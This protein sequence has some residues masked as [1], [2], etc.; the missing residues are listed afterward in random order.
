MTTGDGSAGLQ[1]GPA[2]ANRG[3]NPVG[4]SHCPRF[5]G[6]TTNPLE[7]DRVSVSHGGTAHMM[8]MQYGRIAEPGEAVSLRPPKKC[9]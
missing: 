6:M 4:A 7:S 1:E 8:G 5:G 9:A 3:Q 2:T